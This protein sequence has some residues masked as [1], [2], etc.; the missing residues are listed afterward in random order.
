MSFLTL[1]ET[2]LYWRSLKKMQGSGRFRK[3]EGKEGL[4]RKE[5]VSRCGL[6]ST[7]RRR[8]QGGGEG[9]LSQWR[10]ETG[11]QEAK[12]RGETGEQGRSARLRKDPGGGGL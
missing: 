12:S 11:R 3:K 1:E 2:D 10:G 7:L 4:V 6:R 8:G 5:D 9:S